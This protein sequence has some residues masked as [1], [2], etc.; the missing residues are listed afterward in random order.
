MTTLVLYWV[1]LKAT[2][3]TGFTVSQC[4]VEPQYC[5][6]VEIS[7]HKTIDECWKL[8]FENEKTAHVCTPAWIPVTQVTNNVGDST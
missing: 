8:E 4:K 2:A 6:F 1:L 7:K 3:K 5:E